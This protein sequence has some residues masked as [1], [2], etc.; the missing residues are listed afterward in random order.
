MT[1]AELHRL[2]TLLMGTKQMIGIDVC[3][4]FATMHSL[5]EAE[6]AA[7]IDSLANETI[8]DAVNG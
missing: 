2:V 6:H 3:G 5:F 4:E 8:L 1:L 7:T